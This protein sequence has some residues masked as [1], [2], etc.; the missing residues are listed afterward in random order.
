MGHLDC[1]NKSIDFVKF[2]SLFRVQRTLYVYMLRIRRVFLNT[3][4][5]YVLYTLE[6]HQR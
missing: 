1:P 2:N 3:V 6:T 5:I 4:D